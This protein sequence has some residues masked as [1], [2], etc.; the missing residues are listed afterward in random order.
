MVQS[1]AAQRQQREWGA[2]CQLLAAFQ[3]THGRLPRHSNEVDGE[4]R[5]AAWCTVQR[6][7]KE[8]SAGSPLSAEERAALEAVPGWQ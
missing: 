2:T 8:G 6:R 5:L 3:E 1:V 4:R 7:R